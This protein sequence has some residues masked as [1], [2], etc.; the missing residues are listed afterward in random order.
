[1]T[2]ILRI[3]NDV[4]QSGQHSN[5]SL[6]TKLSSALAKTEDGLPILTSCVDRALVISR[7]E[8]AAESILKFYVDFIVS[9]KSDEVFN[10]TIGHLLDRSQA[11]DKTLRLRA[12]RLIELLFAKVPDDR[13]F[14]DTFFQTVIECLSKRLSDK[15][16]GVR[17]QGIRAL[18]KLQQPDDDVVTKIAELMSSD[19]SNDVRKT[20]VQ[21]V[22]VCES[23]LSLIVQRIKDINTDVRLAALERLKD[24]DVRRLTPEMRVL[25]IRYGIN[26]RES[27]VQAAGI[28]VILKWL[29]LLKQNVPKLINI[30][31]LSDQEEE[32]ELMT[33]AIL[34]A[35]AT[36]STVSRDLKRLS[37]DLAIDWGSGF[38]SVKAAD[39]MWTW[40]RC[41][42]AKNKTTAAN[43]EDT[44][45][46]L[47]PDMV[48]LCTLMK[49]G[50]TP[51]LMRNEQHQLSIQYMLRL[52]QFLD[53]SDVTGCQVLVT[54]CH[55]MLM[56]ANLPDN[57]VESVLDAWKITAMSVN[58]DNLTADMMALFEAVNEAAED[59]EE[60][61]FRCLLI[62]SWVLQNN[63]GVGKMTDDIVSKLNNA[64]AFVLVCLQNPDADFRC[65]STKCLGLLPLACERFCQYHSLIFQVAST[66][67]EE[68]SIRCVALQSL[69]DLAMVYPARYRNDASLTTLLL[70][71]LNTAPTVL[72][73]LA[74]ESS[75]KLMFSGTLSDTRLFATVLKFF[76][77][78]ETNA[79][80][81]S[82]EAAVDDT[83]TLIGS[84]ARLHQ[85]LSIFCHAF[86]VPGLGREKMVLEC[87]SDLFDS[88]SL[89]VRDEVVP[90]NALQKISNNI[91]AMCNGLAHATTHGPNGEKR[92]S[93]EA[94]EGKDILVAIRLR[95][96]ACICR[97]LMKLGRSKRDKAVSKEYIKLLSAQDP[98]GWMDVH[99]AVSVGRIIRAVM[100][101]YTLDKASLKLLENILDACGEER[102]SVYSE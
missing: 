27:K 75:A 41:S 95:I 32:V 49:E 13:E 46:Y 98:A 7:R 71:L 91:L 80:S 20:A 100:R 93:D 30:I 102:S 44:V 35:I 48:N 53:R 101:C 64:T 1:M 17:A 85:I 73:Y 47:L 19:T 4:Q 8:A 57:L 82:D 51:L 11:L 26:D 99:C 40:A 76:F 16:P 62:F 70:R 69:V 58:G 92:E 90:I 50:V 79:E 45:E 22:L 29:E 52:T 21:N 97:E 83:D 37:N 63:L 36:Q 39:V 86:L 87:I 18:A 5:K 33:G 94:A 65:L 74:V 61:A 78:P 9:T 12:C 60:M 72:K 31:G 88:I 23:T 96:S 55:D 10:Y 28:A 15:L 38:K 56:D 54:L 25:V 67:L 34:H 77:L 66:D 42:Y 3:F 43:A 24:L 6:I 2:D 59:N 14:S 84:E 81:E 68:C 89:Q